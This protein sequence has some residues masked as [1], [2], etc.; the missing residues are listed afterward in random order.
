[1]PSSADLAALVEALLLRGLRP[2]GNVTRDS[3]PGSKSGIYRVEDRALSGCEAGVSVGST[4]E[5]AGYGEIPEEFIAKVMELN[6]ETRDVTIRQ[7]QEWLATEEAA[8]VLIADIREHPN[9]D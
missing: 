2:A 9:Q 3:R 7:I 5:A 8:E 1:V 6:G 4:D